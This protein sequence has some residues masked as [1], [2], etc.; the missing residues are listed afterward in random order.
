[1]KTCLALSPTK[2]NF[3]PLLYTGDLH[4]GMQKAAAFGFDG[5]ELNLRNSDELDQDAIIG[6]AKELGLAVPSFGTG[7]SYFEDGLSLADTRPES[8][9]AVR[10]RLR[11]HIR[12]AERIGAQVVLGSIRGKFSNPDPAAHQA[13]YA[14]AV[15]AT[16]DVAA[17]AAERGVRLTIEPINRYETNFLNTGAETMAFLEDVGAPNLGLLFDTFHMNI[18]EIS[19]AEAILAA[20]DRLW[21]VHLVDS[22]RQAPGMGHTDFGPVIGALREVGY[23]GYLSGEMLPKP[24][25]NEASQQFIEYVSELLR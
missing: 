24:D 10:E 25:D 23:T 9:E 14:V 8:Q 12:F 21:H 6:W 1:M 13:E 5:V 18:E 19:L 11:G 4:L 17:Y 20:G 7:Q 15:D 3:A 22:N 2:A 16:R